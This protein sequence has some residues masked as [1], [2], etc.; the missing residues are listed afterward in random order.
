MTYMSGEEVLE[1]DEVRMR[2]G[3]RDEPGFVI[4]VIAPGSP[5]AEAWS[6]PEGGVLIEGGGI[7]LSLTADLENDEDVVF[8]RRARQAE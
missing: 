4:K 5:D 7:G 3:G 1:G 6:A 2:H 8:V